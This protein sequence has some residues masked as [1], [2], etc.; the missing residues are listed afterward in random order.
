M[1]FAED[2]Y[3]LDGFISAC[4]DTYN[5]A[6][7][8]VG[9][10]YH[11]LNEYSDLKNGEYSYSDTVINSEKCEPLMFIEDVRASKISDRLRKTTNPDLYLGFVD[12]EAVSYT[13]LTLPTICSV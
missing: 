5:L 10:E 6:I 4:T 3:Q 1:L 12:F 9:Y 8:N 7:K 2:L 13:H 11:P